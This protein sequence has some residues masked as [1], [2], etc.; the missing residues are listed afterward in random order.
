[1]KLSPAGMKMVL[2]ICIA[3]MVI[4]AG[5]AAVYL[6]AAALPARESFLFALGVILT[7]ALNVLKITMLERSV[8][9]TVDMEDPNAGKNYIR[10]QYLL[11]YFLTGAVL[12]VIGVIATLTQYYGIVWGAIAGIFTLQISVFTVRAMNLDGST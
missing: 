7:S 8:R 6:F 4:I 2:V 9:K 5:G 1:M 12:V 11:R 3:A 10:L